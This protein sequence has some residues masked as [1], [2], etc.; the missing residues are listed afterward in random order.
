V[1]ILPYRTVEKI[2]DGVVITFID[3]DALKMA[4]GEL[5]GLTKELG[6]VKEYS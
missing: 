3:V 6:V 1:R 4:Q 5:E 2:I